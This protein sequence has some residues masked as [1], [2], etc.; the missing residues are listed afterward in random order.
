MNNY[1]DALVSLNI[2][3][4]YRISPGRS[5]LLAND[6]LRY[7]E[8]IVRPC[9]KLQ[10]DSD[11][12]DFFQDTKN[13]FMYNSEREVV[14][15]FINVLYPDTT[16]T[17]GSYSRSTTSYL[18]DKD[19]IIN[20]KN[21]SFFNKRLWPAIVRKIVENKIFVEDYYSE[22]ESRIFRFSISPQV[23]YYNYPSWVSKEDAIELF[24]NDLQ[25][26]LFFN[27]LE[28]RD[29]KVDVGETVEKI[30]ITI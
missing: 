23:V 11:M 9:D 16:F 7:I 10:K 21:L 27:V 24:L 4:F 6:M 25:N 13:L 17:I 2:V 22:E 8:R 20:I 18:K 14:Q 1:K 19:L 28:I 5:L 15:E 29:V 12:I 3:S 30:V 26:W